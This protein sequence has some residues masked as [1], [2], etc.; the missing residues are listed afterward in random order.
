MERTI[1]EKV[2]WNVENDKN[3]FSQGPLFHCKRE[4]CQCFDVNVAVI[5]DKVAET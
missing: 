2:K 1:S 4:G 3:G 5:P